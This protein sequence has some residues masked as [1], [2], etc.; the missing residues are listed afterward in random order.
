[1]RNRRGG[2]PVGCLVAACR[3]LVGNPGAVSRYTTWARDHP[4]IATPPGPPFRWRPI[5]TARPTFKA[6]ATVRL[7]SRAFGELERCAPSRSPFTS[8]TTSSTTSAGGPGT[9]AGRI[10]RRDPRGAWSQGTDLDYLRDLLAYW[11]DG[12][13]WRAA[14]RE[15][16]GYEH[17][18][19]DVGG[20]S[21]CTLSITV[22]PVAGGPRLCRRTAGRVR[23]WRCCRWSIG[24]ATHRLVDVHEH[25]LWSGETCH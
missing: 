5:V 8:P 15:L 6:R 13:D 16:N 19:A 14:E 7:A 10:P 18:I 25:P 1:M 23:S 17:R 2:Y 12:F 3:E 21:V 20:E 24:W 11:A 9:R 4:V 22:Y